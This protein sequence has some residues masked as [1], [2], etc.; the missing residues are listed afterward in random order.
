MDVEFD[1]ALKIVDVEKLGEGINKQ[2]FES[3]I[4]CLEALKSTPHVINLHEVIRTEDKIY[5]V[6]E[7][8][9]GDFE[10][11][12]KNNKISSEEAWSYMQQIM[13]G[14]KYLY[15]KDIIHRDLKPGNLFFNVK[16]ELKI[17]DFGF[18]AT[19]N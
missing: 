9:F 4:R 18:A 15:E 17:G 13:K 3:E 6:T 10:T 5:V 2:L 7:L 1:V 14:Y 19:T 12:L 16:K 11:H 8:C